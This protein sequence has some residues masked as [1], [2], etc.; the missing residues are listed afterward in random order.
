M[1]EMYEASVDGQPYDADKWGAY[2]KPAGF[3][4]GNDKPAATASAP[5]AIAPAAV[6]EPV[7]EDEAPAPTAPVATAKPSS[8]K[9]EDI[10]AMIRN[11]KQS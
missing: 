7:E 5:K 3:N 2:F 9:A 8:Q 4:A 6:A 11:R 1:K 10:L